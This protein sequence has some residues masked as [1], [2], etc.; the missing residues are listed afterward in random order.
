MV[1]WTTISQI[2]RAFTPGWLAYVARAHD[3]KHGE[4]AIKFSHPA[5]IDKEYAILSRL[6]DA[7]VAGVAHVYGYCHSNPFRAIT[8]QLFTSS[9]AACGTM[10]LGTVVAMGKGMARVQ[11][12][13]FCSFR[14]KPLPRSPRCRQY[15][16][17]ASSITTLNLGTS[18][19][20]TDRIST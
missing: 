2:N 13:L 16:T 11:P 1:S 20:R 18:L 7:G 19:P 8:L 12:A 4:V 3:S 6:K 17:S 9:L 14:L 15:T 5:V 10:E